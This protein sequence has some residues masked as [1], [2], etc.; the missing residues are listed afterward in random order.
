VI[1]QVIDPADSRARLLWAMDCL[2][3]EP[4][5]QPPPRPAA[6]NRGNGRA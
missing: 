6:A 5:E 1:D 3:G 4:R 2:V